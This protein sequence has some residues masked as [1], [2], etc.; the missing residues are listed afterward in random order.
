MADLEAASRPKREDPDL[1]CPI[2][3]LY[4]SE[5]VVT[6]CKHTFCKNCLIKTFGFVRPPRCPMCRY[7][8]SNLRVLEMKVERRIND[9]VR[10]LDPEFKERVSRAQIERKQWMNSKFLAPIIQNTGT[11]IFEVVGA[12]N[13]LVNGIYVVGTVPSYLGPRLYQKPGTQIYMF[14]WHRREWI[15]GTLDRGFENMSSR[16]YRVTCGFIPEDTPPQY[17]WA[18]SVGGQGIEPAPTVRALGQGDRISPRLLQPLMQGTV[19]TEDSH[20]CS[21]C[22]IM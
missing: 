5:P 13:D 4:L 14:R 3:Y 10:Q 2:C 22:S 6:P 16:F 18:T 11:G 19:L 15:I 20:R 7:D 17:H 1:L 12:G 8:C 9:E 21:P